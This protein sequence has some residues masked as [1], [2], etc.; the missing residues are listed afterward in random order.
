M[1]ILPALWSFYIFAAH[2]SGKMAKLG[3]L[4]LS[5]GERVSRS[6]AFTSRS[7][8]GEGSLPSPSTWLC[9][10]SRARAS[11]P[12]CVSGTLPPQQG[13]RPRYL[14]LAAALR[15]ARHRDHHRA[16]ASAH[17]ALEMED[18]LPCAE[19]QFALAMGTVSEGPSRVAC[20]C[21]WPLP[22][23]QACSWP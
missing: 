7:V 13:G 18:L 19:H 11:C 16:F 6:G 21:E 15:F 17:I 9:R 1:G 10:N 20:K 4:A 3:G 12:R 14:L 23:C 2:F 8:T 22:S 5:R